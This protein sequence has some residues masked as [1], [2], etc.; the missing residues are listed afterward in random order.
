MSTMQKTMCDE[1]YFSSGIFREFGSLRK[2]LTYVSKWADFLPLYSS[3]YLSHGK[4]N[5]YS[6]MLELGHIVF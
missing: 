2:H 6:T 1:F 3:V 4:K 5:F